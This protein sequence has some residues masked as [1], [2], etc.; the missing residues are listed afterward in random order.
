MTNLID[1]HEFDTLPEAE[2]FQK[3][4]RCAI[5]L[6]HWSIFED[7]GVYVFEC[8]PCKARANEFNTTH[9]ATAERVESDRGFAA[10]DLRPVSKI[11]DEEAEQIIKDLG[12]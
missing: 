12:Y 9:R 5:C 6:G 7:A 10:M 4:N 2:R 3:H 11:T 8:V 1:D